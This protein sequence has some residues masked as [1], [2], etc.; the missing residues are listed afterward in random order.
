LL[1]SVGRANTRKGDNFTLAMRANVR[2]S[3]SRATHTD[4][5]GLRNLH[6]RPS[7]LWQILTPRLAVR[8]EYECFSSFGRTTGR[9]WQRWC[10]GA[11][12]PWFLVLGPGSGDGGLFGIGDEAVAYTTHRLKVA[13]SARV[14]FEVPTQADDEVVDRARV[15]I[16]AHAPHL[17]QNRLA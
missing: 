10:Q 6:G 11:G 17:L 9:R 12:G 4:D 2:D 7:P 8:R 1:V 14:V 5:I 15:G 13:R 16:V 3:P